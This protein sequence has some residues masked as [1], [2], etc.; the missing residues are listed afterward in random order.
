MDL[1][2]LSITG[3]WEPNDAERQAAWEL[4]V[5]LITRITVVPLPADHGLAREALNSMYSLFATT[6][7]ILRRHG[8]DLAAPKPT[9]Q[10]NFAYLAVAILNLVLRPT[11]ERWHPELEAW[12]NDRPEGTSRWQHERNWPRY[13]EFRAELET[14]RSYLSRWA[15]LL[16][17]VNE[18][19]DLS[20]A[21]PAV[22]AEAEG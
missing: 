19:P 10:Y 13:R 15:A 7:E 2:V 11:L 16:A 9:G 5:E 20:D 1:K 12:E 17:K 22:R 3:T 14:T 21:I 4:Y 8:P 18:I 6:R